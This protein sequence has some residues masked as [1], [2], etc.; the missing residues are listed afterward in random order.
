MIPNC[1]V[2]RDDIIQAEDIFGPNLVFL[3]G[4]TTR[5]TTEHV[6]TSW[7]SIPQEVIQQYGEVTLAMDVMAINKIPFLMTT[8]RKLH[9]G[10]AELICNKKNLKM[11]IQQV[12]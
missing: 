11:S 12:A 3:Q 2:T 10:T 7:T 8:S 5:Q 4:K 1:N 9:F 6:H